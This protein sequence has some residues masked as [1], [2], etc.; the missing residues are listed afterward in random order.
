MEIMQRLMRLIETRSGRLVIDDRNGS[1][2]K[3]VK[4][5]SDIDSLSDIEDDEDLEEDDE[6]EAGTVNA[7]E[8]RD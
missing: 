1:V 4:P 5:V 6:D 7:P 8:E 3:Y 2:D